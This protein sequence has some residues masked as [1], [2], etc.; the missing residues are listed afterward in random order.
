VSLMIS[1]FIAM[2]M[3]PQHCLWFLSQKK[4]EG[5]TDEFNTPFFNQFRKLIYWILRHRSISL[6]FLVSALII[7]ILGFQFVVKLFFPFSTRPQLMVDYWAPAGTSIHEVKRKT[8][9][10]EA[11]FQKENN[12]ES[13]STFVGAGPPRFYLPVDPEFLYQN[14]GQLLVNFKGYN[15]IDP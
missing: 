14:Y 6:I 3:T 11:K 2:L 4:E 9:I 7:S 5:E 8:D 15:D 13:V 10:I 12:V 1:W